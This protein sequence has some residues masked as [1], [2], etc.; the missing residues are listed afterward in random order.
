MVAAALKCC[1]FAMLGVTRELWGNSACATCKNPHKVS[2]PLL[3]FCRSRNVWVIQVACCLR[4]YQYTRSTV[5]RACCSGATR[6]SSRLK[7]EQDYSYLWTFQERGKKGKAGGER[8]GMNAMH[9]WE[10][11]LAGFE[12]N[13]LNM[14][15]SWESSEKKRKKKKKTADK[16]TCRRA[17]Q[18]PQM[19]KPQG[20]WDRSRGEKLWKKRHSPLIQNVHFSLGN[21]KRS[22]WT[23][24]TD[25]KKK[26]KHT[27][28]WGHNLC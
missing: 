12:I 17:T 19:G 27:A 7:R 8:K 4:Q 23:E 14:C 22:N 11:V 10:V 13:D 25:Q 16:S 24:G 26:K 21:L 18:G 6:W 28:V 20:L 9:V 1:R 5:P 3:S 15:Y 2:F